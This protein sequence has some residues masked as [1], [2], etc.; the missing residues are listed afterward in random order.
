MLIAIIG[1]GS[2]ANIHRKI[3]QGVGLIVILFSVFVTGC[4][5][6]LPFYIYESL[7][8]IVMPTAWAQLSEY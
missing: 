3:P 6:L 2:Y 4:L 1:Y 8:Y 7:N 5:G